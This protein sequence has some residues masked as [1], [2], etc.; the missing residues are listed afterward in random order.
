MSTYFDLAAH[1]LGCV[2]EALEET[3]C[4]CPEWRA[5][6]AGQPSWD[7]CCEGQLYVAVENVYPS[8]VFPAATAEPVR[9]GAPLAATLVVGIARCAVSMDDR[10][11]P[12]TCEAQSSQA[13]RVYEDAEAV[14][15]GTICCLAELSRD[16]LSVV[17][18]Q[19]FIGPS[20]GCVGS[21][22]R[23]SVQLVTLP[24]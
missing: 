13:V 14:M 19:S 18:A 20:G 8:L 10:G 6:V 3:T 17:G 12:P 9:C 4:G 22:L 24:T 15:R 1:L 21:E 16:A 11:N 5:V 2:C 23:V 7:V